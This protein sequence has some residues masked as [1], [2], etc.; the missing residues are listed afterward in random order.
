MWFTKVLCDIGDD[1][2]D[3]ANETCC[4]IPI[5]Q[6]FCAIQDFIT[7]LTLSA[8]MRH[9]VTSTDTVASRID[10]VCK[11]LRQQVYNS[12]L[13]ILIK[14]MLNHVKK[15]PL[16]YN[17]VSWNWIFFFSDQ[18][19]T[20][21]YSWHILQ[22]MWMVTVCGWTSTDALKLKLRYLNMFTSK[23]SNWPL[24]LANNLLHRS[25]YYV[26]IL[27]LHCDTYR[28]LSLYINILIW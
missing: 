6:S 1:E 23:L 8:D 5:Y 26:K 27:I 2:N 7:A 10:N 9:W 11:N 18:C 28:T 20:F 13:E 3:G 4:D 17:K 22:C 15:N 14:N 12:A 16:I 21:W 19:E 24:I 25:K